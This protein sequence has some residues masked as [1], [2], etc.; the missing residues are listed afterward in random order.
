MAIGRRF[1]DMARSELNSLLDKAARLGEGDDDED[2]GKPDADGLEAFSEA[3]LEAELERRRLDRELEERLAAAA[4]RAKASRPSEAPR[5]SSAPP[6]ASANSD[7]L[8]KAY[9]ALELPRTADF[10]TVKQQYRKLMR[11]YHPDHHTGSPDKEKAAHELTQKLTEAYK[12][13]EKHLRTP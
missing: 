5:S 6:P 4:K 8:A 11:K 7:R 12:L 13:L 10:A 2:G 1:F 3:E 9:A